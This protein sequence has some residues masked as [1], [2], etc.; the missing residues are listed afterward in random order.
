MFG[1][2]FLV[3]TLNFAITEN[4]ERNFRK[5]NKCNICNNLY[6]KKDIR[7]RNHNQ[8]KGK[9]IGSRH[10]IWKKKDTYNIS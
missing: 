10:Q 2:P 3:S 4:D 9:Y 5:A 7:V 8:V 1:F 6:A